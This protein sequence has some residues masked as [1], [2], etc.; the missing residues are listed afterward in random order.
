YLPQDIAAA[1]QGNLLDAVMAS[2][3]GRD[4]LESRLETAQKAL[5][6]AS[7]EAEQMELAGALAELHEELEHFEEHYGRHRAER[8]LQGL[9]FKPEQ[10]ARPASTLSGGWR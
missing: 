6:G 4:G 9:G 7:G 3:P 8:I 10:F 5:D 2:V 1:P